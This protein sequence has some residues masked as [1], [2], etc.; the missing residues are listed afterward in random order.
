MPENSAMQT[1]RRA[2]LA[3]TV[4]FACAAFLLRKAL[5]QAVM[6]D[7]MPLTL[8]THSG[9]YDFS[10]KVADSPTKTQIGLR[11]QNSV[12]P[13]GGMIF[14]TNVGNVGTVKVVTQGL[15]LT[16]D[17]LFI[18]DDGRV[19]E[20]HPWVQPNSDDVVST[21]PVAAALQLA[22][23]TIRRI[24]ITF[25]DRVLSSMFHQTM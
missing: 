16:T 3:L 20:L 8:V 23:G 17:I 25:G 7:T 15:M 24:G 21:M 19:V 18:S 13:D 4:G 22:G 10:V 5:A 11:Y 2:M 14:P 1:S 6:F 12:P 9:R